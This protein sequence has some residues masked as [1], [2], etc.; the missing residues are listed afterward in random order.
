MSESKRSRTGTSKLLRRSLFLLSSLGLLPEMFPTRTMLPFLV[1]MHVSSRCII[2]TVRASSVVAFSPTTRRRS[3]SFGSLGWGYYPRVTVPCH[4][5]FV[6]SSSILP[7]ASSNTTN[8]STNSTTSNINSHQ[9]EN[10][11]KK[12]NSTSIDPSNESP[13]QARAF[14][15]SKSFQWSIS[16]FVREGL[17]DVFAAIG[18]FSSSVSSLLKDPFKVWDQTQQPLLAFLNFLKTSGIGTELN[19]ALSTSAL[20]MALLFRVHA[21]LAQGPSNTQ[22]HHQ[23][24]EEATPQEEELDENFWQR[25]RRYMRYATA[26]Y[27]RSMI[28][29][30]T[31]EAHGSFK[32]LAESVGQETLQTISNHIQVPVQDLVWVEVA[33]DYTTTSDANDTDHDLLRHLVAVDHIHQEVVLA[34]RG[35][36]S[37]QEIAVD[38]TS[39]S[40]EGFAGGEAHEG[41]AKMA[42]RLWKKAGPVIVKTLQEHPN[43]GLVVTGHSLGAG[44]ASLLTILL[45]QQQQQRQRYQHPREWSQ[46]TVPMIPP[47]TSVQCFAFASPPVFTPLDLIPHVTPFITNFIHERDVVPF[48][49]VYSVRHLLASLRAIQSVPLSLGDQLAIIAGSQPPPPELVAAVQ[50]VPSVV[51]IR[52][53]PRLHVPAAKTIWL[54]TPTKTTMSQATLPKDDS[55]TTA[56]TGTTTTY[57]VCKTLPF[58]IRVHPNMLMDH[59]PAR[60]EHAL[61]HVSAK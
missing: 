14:S 5:R 33:Y 19:Q 29:A 21:S 22:I 58:E 44:T 3:S 61:E 16:R 52:G 59:F 35:T 13:S 25:A 56:T 34:I 1:S 47:T 51:P 60:Y 55:T 7:A 45:K 39:F 2:P 20:S 11:S 49:S 28:R 53:A 54:H 36:F 57:T 12:S 38:L 46:A 40:R 9:N 50:T 32:D 6:H 43:Y 48:L 27:G 10:I 18:F 8:S 37:I 15:S 42:E 26:V 4:R 30:A 31:I 41:M 17:G 24:K 23:S